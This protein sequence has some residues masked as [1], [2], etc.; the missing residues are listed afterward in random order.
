MQPGI[1]LKK[2]WSD[3]D[4]VELQVE[5]S[6][7]SNLFVLETYLGHED[8]K[9]IVSDLRRF[10]AG[11]RSGLYDLKLGQL[12]PEFAGGA[13]SARM[14]KK[15]NEPY[16]IFITTK[17]QSQF[18]DFADHNVAPEAT[19]YLRSAPLLLRGFI[20]ELLEV[21]EHKRDTAYLQATD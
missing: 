6:D 17:C 8:M 12:G 5:V 15:E 11:G 19:I 21:A 2:I 1:Y 20:D 3:E 14:N 7:G 16:R 10:E 18:I 9:D 13:L 4:V